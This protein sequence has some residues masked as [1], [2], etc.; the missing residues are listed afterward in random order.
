MYI[1]IYIY[2]VSVC[3]HDMNVSIYSDIFKYIFLIIIT[4]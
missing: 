3:L 4:Y 1:Y 2:I